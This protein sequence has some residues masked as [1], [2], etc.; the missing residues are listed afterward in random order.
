VTEEEDQVAKLASLERAVQ[1]HPTSVEAWAE[2]GAAYSE[3]GQHELAVSVLRRA[4]RLGQDRPWAWYYLSVSL[5]EMD[6]GEAALDAARKAVACAQ[7]QCAFWMRVNLGR[8]LLWS[9]RPHEAVRHLEEATRMAP[10]RT[11]A[12]GLLGVA[13]FRTEQFGAAAEY[14][15]DALRREP[16]DPLLWTYLGVSLDETGRR[17]GAFH[18]LETATFNK[19]DYGWAWGRLGKALRA[20]GRHEEAVRAYDK[21][22]EHGFAPPVLWSDMGESAAELRDV[23]RLRRACRELGRLD[24]GMAKS[25]RR[26]LRSLRSEGRAGPPVEAHEAKAEEVCR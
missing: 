6:E 3:A 23:P 16:D 11:R 26:R 4:T 8:Q 24:A 14:L 19:P 22:V 7:P 1:E 18:A 13:L 10:T 2:L 25:L 21:S 5:A 17:E 15:E 12:V 9:G 20:L